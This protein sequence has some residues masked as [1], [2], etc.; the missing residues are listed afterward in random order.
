MTAPYE[1]YTAEDAELA[2]RADP[3][4]KAQSP[5]PPAIYSMPEDRLKA[6]TDWIENWLQDL[7]AAHQEKLAQWAEEERA[8][9]ARYLGDL[10]IPFLGASGIEAP[11]IAMGVDPVYARLDTGIFK[12]DR[13]FLVKPL[14]KS[15]VEDS[16]KLEI[17]LQFIQQHKLHLRRE[18]SPGLLELTKHGTMVLKTCYDY[19]DRP[20][21]AYDENYKVVDK[22]VQS[23]GARIHRVALND[24]LFPPRYQHLQDCPIVFERLR[25]TV[26]TLNALKRS[27]KYDNIDKV[28]TYSG[29]ESEFTELDSAQQDSAQHRDNT[30][31]RNEIA[32][33]WEGYCDYDID[34]DGMEER[35][36]FTYNEYCRDFI[37][38]R[39]NWYFHQLK[40]YAVIPYITTSNSL[41]G[42]GLGEMLHP[43]QVMLTKWERMAENNAY[44]ANTR[45]FVGRNSSVNED[46]LRVFCARIVKVDDP[47]ADLLPL[48]IADIYPSTLAERQNIIGL[49]EKRTGISDYLTGRESPIVGS[50]ATATSTLALIQ[51]G[52]RRVEQVLE[53]IRNGLSESMM[54]C[55]Y[56]WIQYGI[57]DVTDIAFGDDEVANS[58]HRFFN[59]ID[60]DNIDGAIAIDLAAVD[61]A[62]NKIQQ[63]QA[64]LALIQIGMQY[65]EKLVQV[66]QMAI[67]SDPRLQEFLGEVVGAARRMFKDLY[68]KYDIPNSDMYLPDM[69]AFLAQLREPTG[70]PG[71]AEGQSGLSLVPAQGGGAS[72]GQGGTAQN[73][74]RAVP[75]VPSPGRSRSPQ[76]GP[77][78]VA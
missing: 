5:Y 10:T 57:D 44:L 78:A 70:L 21:K 7:K 19:E 71:G 4:S 59:T 29:K 41:Y 49:A 72:Q 74:G 8:Y 24:F 20:I 12:G 67:Q 14:R 43:F 38:I 56:L 65:L 61:A 16:P 22:R 62:N 48:Q 13:V 42:N 2:E 55:F 6:F 47:S 69:E 66:A 77:V 60:R 32:G 17:W 30:L 31:M 73:S 35:V 15:F 54:M 3:E 34:G 68:D 9:R 76:S 63:Q 64:Q 40:P 39:L 25:M 27:S 51:E 28:V 18:V 46:V 50:R 1:V 58:V 33:L 45:M 23:A 26:G 52:T 37:Q 36:V 75:A 11:L 53:N